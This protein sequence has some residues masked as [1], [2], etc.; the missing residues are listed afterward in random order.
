MRTHPIQSLESA[1][2]VVL[3]RKASATGLTLLA[4]V[5]TTQGSTDYGPA[6]W[7]PPCNANYNTTGSGHKFHVIHD[8]EGY[9]WNTISMFN[10]CGYTSASIHYLV[11]GKKDNSSDSAPGEVTQSVRDAYYAWHARCWNTHSIGTEHAGYASNPACYTPEL[12]SA[13]AGVT[14]NLAAKFGWAKDR[15]H[16]I[17]HGQ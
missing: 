3:L 13:S 11:N 1:G 8:I 5:A 7:R 14:R 15:N 17:G 10:A 6:V 4:A 12:Y 9:Y 16:V 2:A